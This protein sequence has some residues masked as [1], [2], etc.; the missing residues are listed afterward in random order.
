MKKNIALWDF[1]EQGF[2]GA[3]LGKV[4]RI[5]EE[6]DGCLMELESTKSCFLE[7]RTPTDGLESQVDT[8]RLE[9]R[10]EIC[11]II[12]S[13]TLWWTASYKAISFSAKIDH[14]FA[15]SAKS[16]VV[17]IITAPLCKC[18]FYTKTQNMVIRNSN[19]GD[20]FLVLVISAFPQILPNFLQK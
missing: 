7:T 6:A 12:Y 15:I 9:P 1:T 5:L 11:S 8:S 14:A 17:N 3:S 18:K 4:F 13:T 2:P 16:S 20:A 19:K 10:V